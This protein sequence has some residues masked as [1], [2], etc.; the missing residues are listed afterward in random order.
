MMS[1]LTSMKQYLKDAGC[2]K[3]AQNKICSLFE[4]KDYVSVMKELRIVRCNLIEEMHK[5]QRRVDCIDDLIRNQ[6]KY[7]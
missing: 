6:E 3:Q 4:Q 2:E 1:E 7:R 5:V